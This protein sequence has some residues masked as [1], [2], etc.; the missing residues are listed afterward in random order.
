MSRTHGPCELLH[1]LVEAGGERYLELVHGSRQL[2][3]CPRSL[4][5]DPSSYILPL[6]GEPSMIEARCPSSSV[7]IS[8]GQKG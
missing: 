3:L 5:G 6:E 2:K 8:N 1:E 7:V 4:G